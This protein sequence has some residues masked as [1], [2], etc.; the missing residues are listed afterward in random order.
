M[1]IN[2]EKYDKEYYDDAYNYDVNTEEIHPGLIGCVIQT[3]TQLTFN[4][5]PKSVLDVGCGLGHLVVAF[6]KMGV[7][8]EG[9]D[10]SLDADKYRISGARRHC[11]VQAADE[12]INKKYDL[13]TCIEVAEHLIDSQ[14]MTMIKNMCGAANYIC[15][16]SS[17]D[18]LTEETHINVKTPGE[19]DLIFFSH[20]F[21]ALRNLGL[22][23]H[24]AVLYERIAK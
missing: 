2:Q 15:F 14:C 19:W 1:K 3:A 4:L 18:N 9:F 5:S 6:R 21:R 16:S 7:K 17:P 24:W 10:F 20:G 23:P 11:W 8:A 12:D 22:C 13:I